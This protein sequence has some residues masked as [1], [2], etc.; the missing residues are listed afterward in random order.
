MPTTDV[1]EHIHTHVVPPHHTP[2]WHVAVG[3]M[4][5]P[6]LTPYMASCIHAD[7]L[8]ACYASTYDTTY[9]VGCV[10]DLMLTPLHTLHA[11]YSVW[12]S[13]EVSLHGILPPWH[14]LDVV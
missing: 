5:H 7:V 4:V 14:T 6:S 2:C 11:R 12:H 3:D 8:L 9:A 13:V 1:G 10:H